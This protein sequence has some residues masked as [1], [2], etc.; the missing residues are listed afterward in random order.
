MSLPITRLVSAAVARGLSSTQPVLLTTDGPLAVRVNIVVSHDEPTDFAA[1]LDLIWIEP[2]T[3]VALRRSNR[4]QS[5]QYTHTW[6]AA[7]EANF[8]TAQI[9]DEPTPADQ[10]FLELDRNVGNPHFLTAADLNALDLT[11][12]GSLTAPLNVRKAA[13][14]NAYGPDE[15][16]PKSLIMTAVTAAQALAA[17]VYQNL[18]SIRS[19]L[20]A[21]RTRVTTSEG[22]IK[23]LE[24]KFA[25]LPENPENP[26]TGQALPNAYFTQE[27]AAVEW[28][29]EHNLATTR[30][31]VYVRKD[32]GQM[33]VPDISESVDANS[34]RLTFAEARAGTV[35]LI[36]L[37]A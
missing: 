1:P 32:D 37:K 31:D 11:V 17:S 26:G 9:W 19:S 25:A 16:L 3:L 13:D 24:D 20:T 15:V 29:I 30:L 7:T 10:E 28:I 34:Y 5:S 22:K 12:G 2:T 21:V 36:G 33:M 27:E 14:V 18:A 4:Q 23:V 8:W 35:V 6:I